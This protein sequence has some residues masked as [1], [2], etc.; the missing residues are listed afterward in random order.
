MAPTQASSKF[1]RLAI[2]VSSRRLKRAARLC[3][4]GPETFALNILTVAVEGIEKGES[5]SPKVKSSHPQEIH[6]RSSD[7][8]AF[9]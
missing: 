6:G 4:V 3:G 9:S 7:L 8:T 5:S 1:S 2:V